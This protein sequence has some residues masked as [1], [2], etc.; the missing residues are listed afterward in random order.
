MTED[1]YESTEKKEIPRISGGMVL[2]AVFVVWLTILYAIFLIY[3]MEKLLIEE[4]QQSERIANREQLEAEREMLGVRKKT[5]LEGLKLEKK[6][7]RLEY[8]T[9]AVGLD[10]KKAKTLS[11]R[12]F[13]VSM[14]VKA[15]EKR[16][17][18]D[19]DYWIGVIDDKSIADSK[20]TN[21]EAQWRRFKE[22][23]PAPWEAQ[24]SEL[25]KII[26]ELG[27]LRRGRTYFSEISESID[28]AVKS[29]EV[30]RSC[31]AER[32]EQGLTNCSKLN[33]E[34]VSAMLEL[35]EVYADLMLR[36]META[37]TEIED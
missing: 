21:I 36:R 7:L 3:W 29:I 20:K 30:M 16:N 18:D 19:V 6:K 13:G 25:L 27:E 35:E 23:D 37:I 32:N 24:R 22:Q 5:M 33:H 17:N 28:K 8:E 15:D 1:V 31:L 34:M 12:A 10:Q 11:D 14:I 9:R 26:E 2:K 4:R